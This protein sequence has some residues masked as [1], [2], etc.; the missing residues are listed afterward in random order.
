MFHVNSNGCL[1][2]SM[3]HDSC[4]WNASLRTES[5]QRPSL[6]SL[7][8]HTRTPPFTRR[9]HNVFSVCD[10]F[11]NSTYTQMISKKAG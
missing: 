2:T 8:T 1:G 7:H 10:T 11:S 6:V 5:P 9:R 4:R 3:S